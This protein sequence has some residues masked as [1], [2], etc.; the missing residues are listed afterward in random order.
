MLQP[1][2]IHFIHLIQCTLYSALYVLD[3]YYSSFLLPRKRLCP[4]PKFVFLLVTDD[5]WL[6]MESLLIGLCPDL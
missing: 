5:W 4:A 1:T 3:G 2:F 6:F